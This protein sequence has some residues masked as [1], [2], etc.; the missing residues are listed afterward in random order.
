MNPPQYFRRTLNIDFFKNTKYNAPKM[1]FFLKRN[2][3]SLYQ[4]SIFSLIV[5]FSF[6]FLILPAYLNFSILDDS[7]MTPFYACFENIDQG[8]SITTLD[9]KEKILILTFFIEHTLIANFS[10][11]R[12]PN[13]SYQLPTLNSK[14]LILR[15]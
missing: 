5:L 11:D 7:D 12:V 10:R 8:N 9:K 4:K 14:S 13:L 3:K 1:R 6:W 2:M 15:C